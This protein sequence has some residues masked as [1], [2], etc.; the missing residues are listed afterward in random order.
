M[1]SVQIYGLVFDVVKKCFRTNIV[2]IEIDA[3]AQKY[4]IWFDKCSIHI[5]IGRMRIANVQM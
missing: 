2:E 3:S 4:G 1:R 5:V